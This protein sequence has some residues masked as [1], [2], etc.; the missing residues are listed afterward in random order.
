MFLLN[1]GQVHIPSIQCWMPRISVGWQCSLVTSSVLEPESG[2]CDSSYSSSPTPGS[3]LINEPLVNLLSPASTFR[4][5]SPHW[6]SRAF[7]KRWR[8]HKTCDRW[9]TSQQQP[10][11]SDSQKNT[12]EKTGFISN[13]IFFSFFSHV[14][15]TSIPFSKIMLWWNV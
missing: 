11:D 4:Q 5:Q 10:S 14:Y 2:G 15:Y 13:Q 3:L 12:Q 1:A 6:P 9:M 7:I 8:I